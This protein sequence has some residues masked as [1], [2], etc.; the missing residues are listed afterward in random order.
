RVS[1]TARQDG[2]WCLVPGLQKSGTET[3]Q[4]E[5]CLQD[6]LRR[7][8][9]RPFNVTAPETASLQPFSQF[10]AEFAR[11]LHLS[12]AW[13]EFQL[14]KHKAAYARFYNSQEDGD[15][16]S[17]SSSASSWKR[18]LAR[19]G[20]KL[21]ADQTQFEGQPKSFSDQAASEAL[22][23]AEANFY[24]LVGEIWEYFGPEID[25]V[26]C[27]ED[28]NVYHWIRESY[29]FFLPSVSQYDCRVKRREDDV[30][31]GDPPLLAEKT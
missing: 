21:K 23:K 27:E 18:F 1:A 12:G 31:A 28:K 2:L 4:V 19:N 25:D 26:S 13:L 5:Q 14:R 30:L 6:V 7:I 16:S 3:S 29:G 15:D 17:T 11:V 24:R 8:S 10:L 22:H 9:Y 20:L